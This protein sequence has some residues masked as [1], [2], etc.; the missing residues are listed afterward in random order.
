[1]LKVAQGGLFVRSLIQ[2]SSSTVVFHSAFGTS[3]SCYGKVSLDSYHNS[4]F[5]I[6]SCCLI[7]LGSWK[8]R[9]LG[10][11]V[12][13]ITVISLSIISY[14]SELRHFHEFP[15]ETSWCCITKRCYYKTKLRLPKFMVVLKGEINTATWVFRSWLWR[16]VL[17]YYIF[18]SKFSVCIK[19]VTYL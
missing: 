10:M 12:S 7:M 19:Y 6:T 11:N 1:M 14:I 18:K 3:L 9:D 16:N 17:G 5:F 13:T 2:R 15:S 8:F 4:Q